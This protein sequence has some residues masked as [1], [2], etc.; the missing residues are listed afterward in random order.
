MSTGVERAKLHH[1]RALRG[2]FLQEMNCQIR[3]D[4][5]HERGWTD[6]YLLR[7]DGAAVGYGAVMGREIPDRDTVFEFFVIPPF[8][9]RSS[10]LFQQLVA[11]SDARYVECQSN[12]AGLSA[13]VYEFAS[14]ISTDVLLFADHAV[15]RHTVAGAVCRP[16]HRR[17]QIFPHEVEPV[18]EYVLEVAGDVVATSGFMLHYNLPFADLYMEVRADCR[19]RGYATFLL[20]EVKKQCY[21]AGRI[22]AARCDMWNAGSRG[23]LTKAGL[24]LC[25][26]MLTGT[27]SPQAP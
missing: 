14:N 15:T 27:L 26:S 23:A 20:Q 22:P 5:C 6:S 1:I 16:K 19:R 13:L 25:G 24:R 3:Y 9:S 4:A 11:A 18:G 7:V 2:L 12:D 21:L 17:D 10:E 8:R